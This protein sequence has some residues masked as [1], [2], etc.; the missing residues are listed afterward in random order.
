MM[1]MIMIYDDDDD[2]DND[3]DNDD[4]NDYDRINC[5]SSCHRKWTDFCKMVNFLGKLSALVAC[6]W[7]SAV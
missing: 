7:A 6:G 3:D 5:L 2:N 1:M 4:H